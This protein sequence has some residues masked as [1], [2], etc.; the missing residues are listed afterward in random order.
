MSKLATIRV[1]GGTRA[2]ALESLDGTEV[3]VD[4]GYESVGALLREPDWQERV[5]QS[6]GEAMAASGAGFAPVVPQPSKVICVG[7]NYRSHIEEMGRELPE[8]PMLFAKYA[9]TLTGPYDE[10]EKPVETSQLDWECEVAVVIG[11]SVR[12]AQEAEA[13]SAIAGFTALN[14]ISVRDWQSR[15]LQW[16]QGKMWEATTPVGPYLVTP[17][18]LS[19]GVRP[20]LETQLTVDGAVKQSAHTSDL[21]F[22]PVELVKYISTIITLHP[23][24]LIATGTNGGVGMAR[25]PKEFLEVGQTVEAWVEGIGTMR[26]VIT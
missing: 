22:D 18:E 21:L 19:G 11:H 16:L 25:C 13:V 20:A 1:D 15:T 17:D 3:H 2:V 8:F 4:L 24:D 6:T 9:D 12:R 23:G 7:H 10:I 5:R 14:D 26:N